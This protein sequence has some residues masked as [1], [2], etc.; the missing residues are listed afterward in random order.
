MTKRE[1][2]EALEREVAELKARATYVLPAVSVPFAQVVY[3]R[4]ATCGGALTQGHMCYGTYTITGGSTGGD[5][6]KGQPTNVTYIGAA[7]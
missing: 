1:R 2:I 3:G 7:S 6:V 4:C 5:F